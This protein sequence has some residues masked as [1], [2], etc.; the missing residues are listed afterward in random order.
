MFGIGIV[1]KKLKQRRTLL[2][3]TLIAFAKCCSKT[4]KELIVNRGYDNIKYLTFFNESNYGNQEAGDFLVPDKKPQ[5][6]Y[7][8]AC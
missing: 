5:E 1:S 4:V 6:Y 3:S 8:K 7:I 2:P